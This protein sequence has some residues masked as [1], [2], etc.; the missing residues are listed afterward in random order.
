MRVRE[1][2]KGGEREGEKERKSERER[3]RHDK[4]YI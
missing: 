1:L 2:K 4:I 3:E